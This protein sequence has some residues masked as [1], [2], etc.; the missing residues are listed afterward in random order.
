M[1]TST[2]KYNQQ[3][4]KMVT[5]EHN[6]RTI[7]FNG[8]RFEVD[9][10]GHLWNVEDYGPEWVAYCLHVNENLP[11]HQ[12]IVACLNEDSSLTKEHHEVIKELRLYYLKNYKRSPFGNIVYRTC[13]TPPN[14]FHKLFP[15]GPY[16]GACKIA[17]LPSRRFER[18]HW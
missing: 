5:G 16:D 9:E 12:K 1:Q 2:K 7:A 15:S 14:R 13:N 6:K 11:P 8:R 4:E 10:D 18:L 3:E 17:G